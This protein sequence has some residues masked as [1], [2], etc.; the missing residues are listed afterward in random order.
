MLC[1]AYCIDQFIILSMDILA[2]VEH[3]GWLSYDVIQNWTTS[4]LWKLMCTALYTVFY[5]SNFH[6]ITNFNVHFVTLAHVGWITRCVY[7]KF[8]FMDK[9]LSWWSLGWKLYDCSQKIYGHLLGVRGLGDDLPTVY[10]ETFEEYLATF[11]QAQYSYQSLFNTAQPVL[12]LSCDMFID[13][14]VMLAVRYE[15]YI[16]A[17]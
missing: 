4:E 5:S 1:M 3:G 7:I 15:V 14:K 11:M 13:S 8:A 10:K 6:V 2:L 9:A 12:T 16:L 17:V